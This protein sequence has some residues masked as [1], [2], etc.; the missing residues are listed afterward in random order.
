MYLE[1]DPTQMVI[2]GKHTISFENDS[3]NSLKNIIDDIG[4]DFKEAI[5]LKEK[6]NG[7]DELK[8]LTGLRMRM[9]WGLEYDIL[10]DKLSVGLLSSTYFNPH[11]TLTE[12]TLGSV[13]KPIN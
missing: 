10:Q 1:T 12:L 9:N 8:T 6:E 4:D 2:T 3:D 13:Y 11:K 5:N 7:L